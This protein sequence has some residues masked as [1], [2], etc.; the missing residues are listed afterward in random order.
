MGTTTFYLR[1]NDFGA[2]LQNLKKKEREKFDKLSP[3]SKDNHFLGW[4]VPLELHNGNV[5]ILVFWKGKLMKIEEAPKVLSKKYY[6]KHLGKE[7]NE[8][9]WTV[10]KKYMLAEIQRLDKEFKKSLGNNSVRVKA[11]KK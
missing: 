9:E 6:S 7:I 3:Y 2:R 4:H 8:Y 10:L 11:A 1:H 5:Y